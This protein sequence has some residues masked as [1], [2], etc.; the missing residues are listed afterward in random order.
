MSIIVNVAITRHSAFPLARRSLE[1]H[2]ASSRETV[3]PAKMG[4]AVG[5]T[6][7]IGTGA[8]AR[9]TGIRPTSATRAQQIGAVRIATK[10]STL[11]SNK[12]CICCTPQD[13]R[14]ARI[15]WL[16][17]FC[18]LERAPCRKRTPR[19]QSTCPRIW[20]VTAR[21]PIWK[22]DVPLPCN[23]STTLRTT[24]VG[25]QSSLAT[26]RTQFFKNVADQVGEGAVT[27]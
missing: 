2:W 25:S 17:C 20:L 16:E 8:P 21:K 12:V 3:G 1:M 4:S 15:R 11:T 10:E 23:C 22:S 19:S 7:G 26:S 14:E 6:A 27:M 9:A 13:S 5:P 24:Q 18:W